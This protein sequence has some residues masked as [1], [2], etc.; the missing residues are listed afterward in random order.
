M[1]LAALLQANAISMMIS[2]VVFIVCVAIVILLFRWLLGVM[3]VTIPQPLMV[4]LGLIMFLIFL[5]IFLNYTGIWA[6]GGPYHH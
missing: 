2:L 4:V 1:L 5:L 6:F 3:G